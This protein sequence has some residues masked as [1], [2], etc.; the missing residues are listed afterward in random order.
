MCLRRNDLPVSEEVFFTREPPSF[1]TVGDDFRSP[2]LAFALSL[3]AGRIRELC[4]FDVFPLE[5]GTLDATA[6]GAASVLEERWDGEVG[7]ANIAES[8]LPPP[9]DE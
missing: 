4:S 1:K 9:N 5:S 7:E 2:C 8:V 3:R 6:A